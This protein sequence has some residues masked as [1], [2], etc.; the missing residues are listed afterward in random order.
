MAAAG[1]SAYAIK[2][3][4]PDAHAAGEA[5]EETAQYSAIASLFLFMGLATFAFTSA[6]KT[7]LDNAWRKAGSSDA[8]GT[9]PTGVIV[10]YVIMGLC[11]STAACFAAYVAYVVSSTAFGWNGYGNGN[12]YAK[13]AAAAKGLHDMR[14]GTSGGGDAAAPENTSEPPVAATTAPLRRWASATSQA[15]A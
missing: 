7:Q 10:G 6:G 9:N 1:M 3:T 13:K 2:R 5:V 12:G 15:S 14:D 8:K 11:Y 4:N